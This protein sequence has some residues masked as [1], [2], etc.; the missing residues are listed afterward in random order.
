MT[1]GLLLKDRYRLKRALGKGGMAE[2]WLAEDERLERPVAIK[3]LSTPLAADPEHLVRFF[4]E[5][6]L[7]ARIS[8]PNVVRV[9]D[10]GEAD[11]SQFLVMEYI[12]AGSVQDLTGEP[13]PPSRAIELVE[14]AA[15][16]AGAAHSIGLV[17]RDIKPA[18]ILLTNEGIP[19]LADFGIA[20]G[21][22][23]ENLTAT[24]TAIGS[25]QYVSPE[26]ASGRAV[27]PASDVYSLGVVL[28]ELLTG[29]RP[30]ESDSAMA[31]AIAHVEQAPP[32]PREL[33]PE[34]DEGLEAVVLR[35]LA[36]DP[37][38][39]FE[40]GDQLANALI[41]GTSDV[42]P[43]ATA[44]TEVVSTGEI[45]HTEGGY[46]EEPVPATRR[47]GVLA[48]LSS[49]FVLLLVVGV[50]AF[51]RSSDDAGVSAAPR[52]HGSV[53]HAKHSPRPK[54]TASNNEGA[55]AGTPTPTPTSKSSPKPR[56]PSLRTGNAHGHQSSGG[57]GGS[58]TGSTPSPEPS[59]SPTSQPTTQPSPS[60]SP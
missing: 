27:V 40:D 18:N 20:L 36:K 41:N 58:G 44:A 26:Q 23:Q 33:V 9:L 46:A 4:N 14:G 54:F 56:Q 17:H 47:I 31:L 19:K 43:I 42:V 15:R 49:L 48:T 53:R 22:G 7:I 34:L 37:E 32:P 13:L 12:G 11:G 16:G 35:C 6:Q 1:P 38:G 51:G 55:V 45:E 57:G 52:N 39:R 3:S 50:F 24:G 5:A 60:S 59:S 8:H 25:P 10:F 28:Y 21:G 30:F 29:R 2:V